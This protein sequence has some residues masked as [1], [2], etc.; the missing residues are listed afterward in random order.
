MELPYIFFPGVAGIEGAL[1][2][3]NFD[4]DLD[5]HFDD[6]HIAMRFKA[7]FI[8]KPSWPNF[9]LRHGA[10]LYG[11]CPEPKGAMRD[12][13]LDDDLDHHSGIVQGQLYRSTAM[14]WTRL[15]PRRES[16]WIF[17]YIR[18]PNVKN[19]SSAV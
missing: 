11:N 12:H 19:E 1:R 15:A 4:D 17:Q 13:H 10:K 16:I 8:D 3:Q 18:L 2:D 5:R 7:S 6:H 14:G 9:A